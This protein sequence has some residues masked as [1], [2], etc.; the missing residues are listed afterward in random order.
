MVSKRRNQ[1]EQ[2]CRPASGYQMAVE[3]CLG[4]QG[5]GAVC[6]GGEGGENTHTWFFSFIYLLSFSCFTFSLSPS[7]IRSL[8]HTIY[9]CIR[10]VFSQES[11]PPWRGRLLPGAAD[12]GLNPTPDL[13]CCWRRVQ[14]EGDAYHT[15]PYRKR[16]SELLHAKPLCYFKKIICWIYLYSPMEAL[17]IIFLNSSFRHT[18]YIKMF[19]EFQFTFDFFLLFFMCIPE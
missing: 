3:S 4:Y 17:N 6:K 16:K 15:P 14:P 10:M 2:V 13:L 1:K 11:E 19:S 9:E 8:S 12:L 7:F 5:L 18:L